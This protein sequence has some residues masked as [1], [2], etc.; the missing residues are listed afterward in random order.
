[1][2]KTFYLRQKI[3]DCITGDNLTIKIKPE[4]QMEGGNSDCQSI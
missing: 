1:M 2:F 3:I 4:K